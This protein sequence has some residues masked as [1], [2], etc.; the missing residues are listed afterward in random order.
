MIV[1]CL[2]DL[3]PFITCFLLFLV[4][5]SVSFIVLGNEIDSEVVE[6][7][8][9]SFTHKTFLQAYRTSIGELG[10]PRYPKLLL[11]EDN[12]QRSMN[13]Y[14]IWLLWYTQTFCMLVVLLNFI[15][16]VINETYNL[17]KNDQVLIN[18]ADKAELNKECYEILSFLK[19]HAEFSVIRF[20]VNKQDDKSGED[21]NLQVINEVNNFIYSQGLK[22]SQ[23]FSSVGVKLSDISHA[24]G[25]MM[26]QLKCKF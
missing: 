5:F 22:L 12:F 20:T 19:K 3:I 15:I 26:S 14:L 9:I 13:I 10:M 8:W 2:E 4:M 17:V 16:A 11:K 24:Q 1:T 18:Y 7:E 21:P 25:T 6:A 23:E